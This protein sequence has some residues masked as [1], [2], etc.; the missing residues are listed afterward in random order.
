M[1]CFRLETHTIHVKEQLVLQS[2]NLVNLAPLLQKFTQVAAAYLFVEN[3]KLLCITCLFSPLR[4]IISH[5]RIGK[6]LL[7]LKPPDIILA[8][9]SHLSQIFSAFLFKIF[10]IK[11]FSTFIF[12]NAQNPI[13]F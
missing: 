5:P 4:Q 12:L 10:Q 3:P 1:V 7:Q 11:Y 8:Y 6:F 2:F 9:F 13:L